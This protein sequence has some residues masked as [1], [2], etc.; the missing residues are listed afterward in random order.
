[1][2]AIQALEPGSPAPQGDSP[3]AHSVSPTVTFV[4]WRRNGDASDTRVGRARG[5]YLPGTVLAWPAPASM[6]A[7]A[8][9][10]P[11]VGA[12]E[13]VDRVIDDGVTRSHSAGSV[14]EQSRSLVRIGRL[15]QA[16][17][18]N[19][20]QA[21]DA[22]LEA[23]RL[24]PSHEDAAADVAGL[25]RSLRH[26]PQVIEAIRGFLEAEDVGARR[27][28]LCEHAV[29]WC[30]EAKAELGTDAADPFVY[31]IDRIDPGHWAVRRRLASIYREQGI[32]DLRR[33]ELERALLRAKSNDEVRDTRFA[34]GEL[35]E[36]RLG[37][38]QRATLHY[39]AAL[40]CAPDSKEVLTALARVFE[41]RELH[42]RLRA[43]LVALLALV[44]ERAERQSV[45]VRLADV[46]ERHFLKPAHAAALLEEAVALAPTDGHALDLLEHCYRAMR[47]WPEYVR[48]VE[49][50]LDLLPSDAER[51]GAL[52]R[53]GRA[54]DSALHDPARAQRAY[55]R[56]CA[57]DPR[58]ADALTELARLAERSD[59]WRGA[60]HCR[61][62]LASLTPA[63]PERARLHVSIG[64]LLEAPDRDPDR[65]RGQY[66]CAA[67][68][69]PGL[70][71]AWEGLQRLAEQEGAYASAARF[72][73]ER[74]ARTDGRRAK[75]R[76]YSE[77]G[78][79]W[80]RAGANNKAIE[81]YEAARAAIPES[82]AV[83]H[84]LL[85]LY[86]DAKREL[87]AVRLCGPLLRAAITEGDA[88]RAADVLRAVAAMPASLEDADALLTLAA[89]ALDRFPGRPE[90]AA[91]GADLGHSLRE[92]GDA[93]GSVQA[94]VDAI[95][96]DLSGLPAAALV[97]LGETVWTLGEIDR[98]IDLFVA[99]LGVDE[100][101]VPALQN[102]VDHFASRGDWQRASSYRLWLARALPVRGMRF[103]GVVDTANELFDGACDLEQAAWVYEEARELEPA[104]RLLLDRLVSIYTALD[105]ARSLLGVQRAI[106]DSEELPALR[107]SRVRS[108]A[109]IAW[110]KLGDA[111]LAMEL[112]EE[113]LD[114]DPTR[115]DALEALAAISKH[116]GRFRDLARAH[117][118]LFVRMDQGGPAPAPSLRASDPNGSV[119]P[120]RTETSGV[121]PIDAVERMGAY[122]ATA[123]IRQLRERIAAA[124]LSGSAYREIAAA[125]R[126]TSAVDAAWCAGSV[127]R[128]LGGADGEAERFASTLVAPELRAA[129]SVLAEG[130]WYSSLLH[131][132]L[133]RPLLA[134]LAVATSA[135]RSITD[136][137]PPSSGSD[138]STRPPLSTK[139][140][141]SGARLSG[142]I[143]D[144]ARILRLPDPRICE[145][146]DGGE[147]IRV[148]PTARP[149]IQLSLAALDT[150]PAGSLPFVVGRA[151]ADLHPLLAVR[152]AAQTVVTDSER[153]LCTP[154]KLRSLFEVAT[155]AVAAG[156]EACI[157]DADA[158][159]LRRALTDQ[160]RS[161][162]TVFVGMVA[163][164]PD[165][166]DFE[167]LHQLL[168]ASATRVGLLLQGAIDRA[169][170][171]IVRERGQSSALPSAELRQELA[172]F[173]VSPEHLA[174]RER[175]GLNV[176]A[177][178]G[179]G[180]RAAQRR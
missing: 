142:L 85:R 70:A 94:L 128:H 93:T 120:G 69:D 105:D 121:V 95:T 138:S 102:L 13:R 34:L 22:A 98:A 3:Y 44:S 82:T 68:L 166:P 123:R 149:E 118:R 172:M 106:A 73:V 16:E 64:A 37:N 114:L 104:S 115:L 51:A 107:A 30:K 60:A 21:L 137:S 20:E 1:M 8:R 109:L 27:I 127:F 4:R 83:A 162:L 148:A 116:D 32:W 163:D 171:V 169:W 41:A 57:F 84:D 9:K 152:S 19:E 35:H 175:L 122:E 112:F 173:T 147:P 49:R 63:A 92:R 24:D 89:R 129:S 101:C 59:D 58:H 12:P 156:E 90:L 178:R 165:A 133:D 47:A 77:L 52:V 71:A 31:E 117:G 43:T 78:V 91:A 88:G 39:E 6:T 130:D 176:R 150:V 46:W 168:E 29:R 160:E 135:L 23:F 67:E 103:P 132:E 45:L 74:I 154:A 145:R 26:W 174:L 66:E 99:A 50:H 53:I 80:E 125:F 28:Q 108:M 151:L 40:A 167:R 2:R 134:A 76:L 177:A 33:E 111:A 25:A 146:P 124:P 170:A 56:A 7:E 153:T 100:A 5:V 14:G 55:R 143:Q 15:L 18:G 86:R 48:T 158:T 126:S 62:K 110:S 36:I 17:L 10:R 144:A 157:G 141:G 96:R 72:L 81:A 136:A 164:R 11:A 161:E 79:L 119:R 159:A 75:A 97:K 131:P 140:T 113:A 65:A 42:D 155:R 139:G 61:E 179:T 54:L 180:E 87:K 38:L